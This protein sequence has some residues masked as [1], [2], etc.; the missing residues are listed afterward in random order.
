MKN[1]SL[2]LLVNLLIIYTFFRIFLVYIR[3]FLQIGIYCK[4]RKIQIF[5][6]WLNLLERICFVIWPMVPLNLVYYWYQF[7]YGVMVL[8]WRDS[9]WLSCVRASMALS[10]GIHTWLARVLLRQFMVG[11]LI[12][13]YSGWSAQYFVHSWR[14]NS[15]LG[16]LS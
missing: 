4:F 11:A 10:K 2:Q 16:N 13:S 7:Q 3:N 5:A 15:S 12:V 9:K 14:V 8:L 1:H 6:L